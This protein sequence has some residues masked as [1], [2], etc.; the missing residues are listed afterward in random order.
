MHFWFVRKY[1]RLVLLT[2]CFLFAN[3]NN[4][5]QSNRKSKYGYTFV[6]FCFYLREYSYIVCE[7]IT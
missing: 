2:V 4:P 5:L 7:I 6:Q 3:A 1:M